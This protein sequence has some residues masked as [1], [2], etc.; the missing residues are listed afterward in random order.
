MEEELSDVK[1]LN[2]STLKNTSRNRGSVTSQ[3]KQK[4]TLP[5]KH[6]I[7]NM[8]NHNYFLFHFLFNTHR[9]PA[10]QEPSV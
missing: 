1:P 7:V 4:Y 3:V 2:T 5:S 8:V 10:S 9:R 6:F